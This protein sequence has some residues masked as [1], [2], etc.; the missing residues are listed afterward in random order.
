MNSLSHS[1]YS[2]FE[3]WADDDLVKIINQETPENVSQY[4][5]SNEFHGKLRLMIYGDEFGVC[6]AVRES[7]DNYK[8]YVIYIDIDNRI[9]NSKIKD[10]HLVLIW[11]SSDLKKSGRSL[12]HVTAPLCDD[13]NKLSNSGISYVLDGES[14][15][16]PF[17]VSHILG[18]NLGVAHLLGFRMSFGKAFICRFCGFRYSELKSLDK[19]GNDK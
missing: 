14:I 10:I 4:V 12:E 16:I 18:G 15:R 2:I 1:E 17:C 8:Q 3:L 11:R 5:R 19:N 6:R 7:S 13:I 9:K